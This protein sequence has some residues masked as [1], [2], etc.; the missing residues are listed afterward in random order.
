MKNHK[1]LLQHL[2]V[3]DSIV[4]DIYRK[5]ISNNNQG[6]YP[7]NV[8]QHKDITSIKKTNQFTNFCISNK[9]LI[10]IPYSKFYLEN[11]NSIKIELD[12]ILTIS[13]LDSNFS[14]YIKRISEQIFTNDW[15]SIEKSF[16][17]NWNSE[18]IWNFGPIE[19]MSDKYYGYKRYFSALTMKRNIDYK[20]VEN[21][22]SYV[23]EF[24][25]SFTST[26]F[27]KP[28]STKILVGDKISQSGEIAIIN[29]SGWSR[30]ENLDLANEFGTIKQL[31]TNTLTDKVDNIYIPLLDSLDS[32]F[33]IKDALKKFF[34]KNYL[35]IVALHEISHT[36]GKFNSYR[37]R[38]GNAYNS[39][40]EIKTDFV[41]Y[42]FARY[43]EEYR[44]LEKDFTKNMIKCNFIVGLDMRRIYLSE[45][46]R[47]PYYHIYLQ[48]CKAN[49]IKPTE[50]N[51]EKL[52]Y[53]YFLE[54]LDNTINCLFNICEHFDE[55][56]ALNYIADLESNDST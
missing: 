4:N 55:K 38:L 46:I 50:S 54:S 29:P 2:S 48:F 11:L 19:S 49:K 42:K 33:S 26:N 17:Q 43:L 37:Q 45:N 21:L 14:K 9:D 25:K 28:A 1:V 39:I 20:F 24:I 51:I 35:I 31:Y 13:D 3:I 18:I 6:V 34:H 47:K 10:E 32:K 40:E 44:I 53:S 12:K 23:D 30:P 56:A 16:L 7:D 22:C 41:A 8:L 27:M 36:I 5:Q 52:D 15:I